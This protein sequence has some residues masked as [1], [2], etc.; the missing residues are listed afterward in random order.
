[1]ETGD[2]KFF[3]LKVSGYILNFQNLRKLPVNLVNFFLATRIPD[4]YYFFKV[5]YKTL[6]PCLTFFLSFLL[7]L[8]KYLPTSTP[9]KTMLL[10]C[11]LFLKHYF[12]MHCMWNI[13]VW[14]IL[15]SG[16]HITTNIP[17]STDFPSCR[18]RNK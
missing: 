9:R 14:F 6:G 16:Q 4:D 15:V 8:R 12:I 17:N 18:I 1:M 11:Y 7:N 3:G 13:Y 5:I 2:R 10:I